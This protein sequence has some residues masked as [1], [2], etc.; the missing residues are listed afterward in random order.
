MGCF[1]IIL[2]VSWVAL[3]P[4]WGRLGGLL[5]YLW[6]PP[7]CGVCG[8]RWWGAIGG[9][10]CHWSGAIGGAIYNHSVRGELAAAAASRFGRFGTYHSTAIVMAVSQSPFMTAS[11]MS[12]YTIFHLPVSCF[13]WACVAAAAAAAARFFN[14]T[15]GCAAAA[16][17]SFNSTGDGTADAAAALH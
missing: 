7:P 5:G 13:L 14:S 10:E 4:H 12:S 11:D 6:G 15:G 9:A 8:C 17:R 3:M 1:S 16:A 2:E